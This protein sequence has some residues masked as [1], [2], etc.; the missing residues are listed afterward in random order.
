M[1]RA[2]RRRLERE[3]WKHSEIPGLEEQK[4]VHQKFILENMKE[5]AAFAWERYR[6]EGKGVVVFDLRNAGHWQGKK[7]RQEEDKGLETLGRYLCE[8]AVLEKKGDWW[9]KDM[10]S[11]VKRYNP[12]GE[13]VVVFM[14]GDRRVS[15]Y[16]FTC[17]PSPPQA[18]QELK[19]QPEYEGK[20]FWLH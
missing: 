18:Y 13:A 17:L 10:A 3:K 16:K 11:L 1:D 19:G 15:A 14:W 5:I 7:D 6:E 20:R 9:D 4:G 12:G 2:E 8:S